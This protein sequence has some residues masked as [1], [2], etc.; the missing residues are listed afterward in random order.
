MRH[1]RGGLACGFE[2]PTCLGTLWPVDGHLGVQA[3]MVHRALGMIAG[4]AVLALFVYLVLHPAASRAVRV[5]A[6]FAA[7]L[8]FTQVLLGIMTVLLSRE[9]VT[10]TVHSTVGA[11][12]LAAVTSL[13]WL[14]NPARP[15]LEAK[16]APAEVVAE[17]L[18]EAA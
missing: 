17:Q 13:Y 11:L 5:L 18:S 9:M 14:A 7:V 1:L 2:F 4:A 16:V 12:T 10:M 6:G 8:T 3:H 15:A